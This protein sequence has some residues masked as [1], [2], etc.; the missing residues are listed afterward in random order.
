MRKIKISLNLDFE[1]NFFHLTN[2][3]LCHNN[4]VNIFAHLNNSVNIFYY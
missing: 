2:I 1:L 4:L 3:Y